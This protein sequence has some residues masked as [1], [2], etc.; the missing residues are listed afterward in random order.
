MKLIH[1][2]TGQIVEIELVQEFLAA[3]EDAEHWVE[4][5]V[6]EVLGTTEEAQPEPQSVPDPAPGPVAEPDTHTEAQ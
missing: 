4:H 3:V 1:Q 5:V 2:I 6:D